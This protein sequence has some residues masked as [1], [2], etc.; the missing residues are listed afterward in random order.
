MLAGFWSD[1]DGLTVEIRGNQGYVLEFGSSHLGKN[2]LIFNQNMP[3][4]KNL[5]RV[6]HESW[7]AEVI[8]SKFDSLDMWSAVEYEKTHI[9]MSTDSVVRDVITFSHANPNS[10]TM[11]RMPASYTPPGGPAVTC[12]STST[13]TTS[14]N[15]VSV[16]N[17]PRGNQT[18]NNIPVRSRLYKPLNSRPNGLCYYEMRGTADL[19][20]TKIPL[21]LY[22]SQ[23]PTSSQTFTLEA[24]NYSDLNE[25][26]PGS[27]AIAFDTYWFVGATAPLNITVVGNKI[28]AAAANVEMHSTQSSWNLQASY[29]TLSLQGE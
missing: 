14:G 20:G 19:A 6:N 28:T 7:E 4:I 25:L 2:K 26:A 27:A 15:I 1:L 17:S 22:L 3:Y 11:R 12:D 18:F 23:K 8:I 9:L 29:L 10:L 16:T 21:I 24:I 5:V 13:V